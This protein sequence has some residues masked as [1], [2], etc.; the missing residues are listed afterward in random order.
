MVIVIFW[1]MRNPK[2]MRA[3]HCNKYDS[4]LSLFLFTFQMANDF[5][6]TKRS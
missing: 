3:H 6:H 2:L 1:E 5:W 4:T